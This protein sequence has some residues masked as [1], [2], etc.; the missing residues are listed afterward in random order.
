[1]YAVLCGEPLPV[2]LIAVLLVCLLPL[3]A[4]PLLAGGG[5]FGGFLAASGFGDDLKVAA[6]VGVGVPLVGVEFP[7]NLSF[8]Q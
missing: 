2:D 5:S 8:A 6:L 1:L 7:V 4:G 3:D